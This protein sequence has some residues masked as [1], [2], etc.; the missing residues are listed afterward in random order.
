MTANNTERDKLPFNLLKFVLVRLLDKKE[1]MIRTDSLISIQAFTDQVLQK[2]QLLNCNTTHSTCE[3]ILLDVIS[4]KPDM[5]ACTSFVRFQTNA[6]LHVYLL[7]LA[8][9]ALLCVP[10]LAASCLSQFSTPTEFR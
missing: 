6:S 1:A 3:Q 4:N 10:A 8:G 2:T 5:N 7:I 9:P